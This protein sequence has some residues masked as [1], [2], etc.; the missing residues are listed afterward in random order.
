[1]K[2]DAPLVVVEIDLGGQPS[3]SSILSSGMLLFRA[4]VSLRHMPEVLDPESNLNY[5]EL[6]SRLPANF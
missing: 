6:G 2:L 5:A 3:I 4:Q 1:M